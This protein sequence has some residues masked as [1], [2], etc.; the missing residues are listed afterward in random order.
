MSFGSLPPPKPRARLEWWIAGGA[1]AVLLAL[2]ALL[3]G[4]FVRFSEP[5]NKVYGFMSGN[6]SLPNC[7]TTIAREATVEWLWYRIVDLNCPG[8]S[9]HF[10]YAKRGTGPGLIVL[11]A[12]MSIDSPVPVSVR[13]ADTDG[14]EILL[15]EPLADGRTAVRL[16]LESGPNGV[17]TT[18]YF[19]HGRETQS[20]T[21]P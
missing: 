10:V 16:E 5:I 6:P 14:F 1:F 11:P 18:K 2:V 4:L 7:R 17:P 20:L 3:F 8:V 13:Q 19:D 12:F 9:Q 15:S 21:R